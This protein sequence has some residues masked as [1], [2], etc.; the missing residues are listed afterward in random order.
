LQ[1][2]ERTHSGEFLVRY[3]TSM[4]SLM[5]KEGF[6]QNATPSISDVPW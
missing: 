6:A 5:E 4:H 2:I 1:D 3:C